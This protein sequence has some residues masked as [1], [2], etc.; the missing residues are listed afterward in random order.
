MKQQIA[1]PENSIATKQSQPNS[2]YVLTY[3]CDI[4]VSKN[5]QKTW[6]QHGT[7]QSY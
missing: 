4:P 2:S 3:T 7:K 1:I 6:G 5:P